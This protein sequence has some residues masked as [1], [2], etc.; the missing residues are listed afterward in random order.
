MMSISVQISFT[1]EG[2]EGK[3][4]DKIINRK[5]KEKLSRKDVFV[6]EKHFEK[7]KLSPT[8]KRTQLLMH[9]TVF[10]FPLHFQG[11]KRISLKLT[12]SGD[13]VLKKGSA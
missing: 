4:V 2:R 9:L 13:F 1:K 11:F 12:T 10:L 8:K 6:R 3:Y 7:K 5:D